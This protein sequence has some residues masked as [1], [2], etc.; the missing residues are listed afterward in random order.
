MPGKQAPI[1]SAKVPSIAELIAG[2]DEV[3]YAKALTWTRKNRMRPQAEAAALAKESDVTV[4]FAGLPNRYESEGADRKHM[5]IPE[6]QNA[7]IS[8][9]AEVSDKVAVVLFNGSPVEMPWKDD[10]EAILEMYL[11]GDGV[12]EGRHGPALWRANP[13]GKLAEPSRSNSPTIPPT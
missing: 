1:N 12:S 9:V 2:R 4:I 10:V 6:N 3:A 7:L 11:G 8:A 5:R 13:S